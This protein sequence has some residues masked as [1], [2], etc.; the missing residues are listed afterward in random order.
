MSEVVNTNKLP[1]RISYPRLRAE[2][3]NRNIT[4]SVPSKG[5]SYSSLSTHVFL[6][7]VSFKLLFCLLKQ[8]ICVSSPKSFLFK[9]SERTQFKYTL[10]LT[11][12]FNLLPCNVTWAKG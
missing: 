12:P 3:K 8:Y 9:Q 7:L 2:S 4:M 5:K 6:F 1:R 10:L 11:T